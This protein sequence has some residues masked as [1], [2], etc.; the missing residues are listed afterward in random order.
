MTEEQILELIQENKSRETEILEFKERKSQIPFKYWTTQW[1][2][3]NEKR[4]CLYWYCVG[5]GN[6]W[7][8]KLLIGI[9]DNWNIVGTSAQLPNDVKSRIFNQ[10]GQRIEIDECITN[11]NERIIIISIPSRQTKQVL[12]FHGTALM[13]IDDKLLVM[14]DKT[15][16]KVLLENVPDRS[17]LE[18]N[19][20][21]I[22]DLDIH[23]INYLKSKKAD[24]TKDNTYLQIDTITLLNQLWLLTVKW[25]P[26]NTCILFLWKSEVTE[27]KLP[28]ISR[29]S[30]VY[31]DRKNN[32][33]DRLPR[34]DQTSPLLLTIEKI[35]SKIQKYNFPLEDISLFRPDPEYQYSEK[36]IE[37]L[38][39][40]S[41]AHRDWIIKIHNS[42]IQTPYNIIFSNPGIFNNDLEKILYYSQPTPYKNQIMADFLSKINLMENERRWLQK[43]F[44]DQLSKWVFVYKEEIDNNAGWIVNIKLDGKIKDINFAKLVLQIKNIERNHL[45]LL[46]KISEW[47][48]IINKDITW[49]QAEELKKLWYVEFIGKSPTRRLRISFSLL[50]EIWQPEKYI[51]DKWIKKKEIKLLIIELI[52]KK[53]FIQIKNIYNQFNSKSQWYIRK[54]LNEMKNEWTIKNSAHGIYTKT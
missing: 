23:A 1:S 19:W 24:I 54:V 21:T 33:E 45:F 38:I 22:D 26:N 30:R 16:E 31:E 28:W 20:T 52:N 17:S 11:K 40:N 37:E 9:Q 35:I 27:Q 34:E 10:T 12:K 18:C 48:N 44:T 6:M 14:D 32:I 43:V 5:I 15:H 42:I 8:W 13:R 3:E 51:I 25:I 50:D 39:A 46:F 29:F 2:D 49:Q 47:Y 7:W 53:S 36:A 4:R 41:L